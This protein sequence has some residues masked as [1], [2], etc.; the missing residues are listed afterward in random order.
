[1]QEISSIKDG[2]EII[3]YIVD[4]CDDMGWLCWAE[5][6][7]G[8]TERSWEVDSACKKAVANYKKYIFEWGLTYNG[9]KYYMKK[10]II[11]NIIN[12]DYKVPFI[13]KEEY[14][15]LYGVSD[16]NRDYKAPFISKEEYGLYDISDTEPNYSV[17]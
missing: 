15:R 14:D 7:N 2:Y 1:M 9:T 5:C 10:D 3:E 12:R 16:I 11:D 8:Y 13:S 6:K 17:W 4:G